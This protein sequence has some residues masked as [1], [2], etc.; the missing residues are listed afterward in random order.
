MEAGRVCGMV[1]ILF[2][3]FAMAIMFPTN[4]ATMVTDTG[5]QTINKDKY[6]IKNSEIVK[7]L[8]EIDGDTY[9]FS[10]EGKMLTGLQMTPDE[11]F[12]GIDGKEQNGIHNKN[13]NL[14]LYTKEG[15]AK[16][17]W[18]EIDKK[19]YYVTEQGY[20][21][22]GLTKIDSRTYF[23]NENGEMTRGWQKTPEKRYFNKNGIMLRG[24]H[25]LNG[26]QYYF[27]DDGTLY[28][29]FI[30]N[31]YY[32]ED[33]TVFVGTKTLGNMT[34]KT[35]DQGYII[36][37]STETG[38]KVVDVARST[39]AG[40]DF[41]HEVYQQF[42]V[43][44]DED[45]KLKSAGDY[46]AEGIAGDT[47]IYKDKDGY[48]IEAGIYTGSDTMIDAKT[49]EE[50]AVNTKSSEF[51]GYFRHDFLKKDLTQYNKY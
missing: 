33:G 51:V 31:Q 22:R 17:G 15:R 1:F 25:V 32:N 6:Y 16:K 5:W 13:G 23:F 9:F 11:R 45:G 40:E 50:V 20:L 43:T 29:G 36:S 24:S 30:A 37:R 27:G 14:V 49:G 44:Y 26:K 12:F 42:G 46:T 21:A 10:E 34:F 4:Y 8:Q 39:E 19:K 7:G 28:K 2:L 48:K 35:D 47:V 38:A 18:H 3:N 41:I